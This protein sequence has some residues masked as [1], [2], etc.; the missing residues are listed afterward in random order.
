MNEE[1]DKPI[2]LPLNFPRAVHKVFLELRMRSPCF[3]KI[4]TL[5]A[6]KKR[7]LESI[8]NL[9]APACDVGLHFIKMSER[10]SCDTHRRDALAFVDIDLKAL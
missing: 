6:P 3:I 7:S 8:F 9:K 5:A 10:F 2:T 1:P 4:Q